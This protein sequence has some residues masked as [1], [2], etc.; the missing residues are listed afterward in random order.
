MNDKSFDQSLTEKLQLI[1]GLQEELEETN[2]GVLLLMQEVEELKNK[3]LAE[4]METINQLQEE[5]DKTN[6]GLIAL[7]I[8][9]E[10]S[11]EKYRSILEAA[12]EAIF[13]FTE[14]GMVETFNSAVINL[15]GYNQVQLIDMDIRTLIPGFEKMANMTEISK[16]IEHLKNTGFDNYFWGKKQDQ[17][18]FPIEMTLGKPIYKDEKL[19][20]LIS[21]DITERKKAEESYRLTAKIFEGSNDAI[22][23]TDTKGNILNVN[24]A[25]TAITGYEK[26]KVVGQNPR[27][28][29]SD[30][31]DN[32]Y[33]RRIW[34]TLLKTGSWNGE[35]WDKRQDGSDYPKWLSI[36][37]VKNEFNEPSHFVGIFTDITERKEAEDKLRQLAHFDPLTHLPNRSLF[38]DRLKEAVELTIRLNKRIAVM[39]L[40]L[41]RFKIVN[42]TLGHQA[43]DHLLIEVA[44]RLEACIRSTDTVARLA[45][46]EFTIILSN[47]DNPQEAALVAKKILAAFNPPINLDGREVFISASI[48]ISIF[49]EDGKNVG[50]LLKNA[51][52]AMYHAKESGRNNYQFF[53]HLINQK[54]LD[55]LEM[56]TNLRNA[57]KC[58]EFLLHYQPQISLESGK[59]IGLE[60]LVRWKHPKLGF[61]P[62]GK[63]IPYAEKTDLIISI[64]EWVLRTA[65]ERSV[66]WQQQGLA[67]LRISVNLSGMQLKQT[68]QVATVAAILADTGLDPNLLELELTES[69]VMENAEVTINTLRELKAM[70][71][72]LSIDDFGTGYS[73]LS[74]L[75]RFPIDTLKIDRSFVKDITTDFDDEAIAST[76]IA[77]AHNLRLKVIAEGVE[78]KEQLT[79]LQKKNC[80]EVQGYYFS[81]P[82]P[83]K[84]LLIFLNS[85]SLSCT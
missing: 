6:K 58:N 50:Q 11:E 1:K 17:Q 41:D 54:V 45:G 74:Y 16:H 75:K 30:R 10:Q 15:F 31:H 29:K 27:L 76:I 35:V 12:T 78:T 53:S 68:D 4:R 70:G 34:K 85:Q 13:T 36:S 19:W 46:D 59:I 23:I 24:R 38:I 80:D 71:I 26:S 55:E 18:L 25:F 61:I 22:V 82:L 8:E 47:L 79:I 57:L 21:R 83:E 14:E 40:D 28:M 65:C 56:Q 3:K 73:S 39:F 37:C 62:P 7:T 43:G 52:A 32:S 9:L 67:P 51:D 81:K 60:V 77:M 42:D 49:P 48:G 84:E 63:F 2:Q 44:H 64:G 20:M 5:L 72:R 33:Y 69:V 66:F